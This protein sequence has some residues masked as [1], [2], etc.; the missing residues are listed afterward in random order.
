MP[1]G[2]GVQP[3][4]ANINNSLTG[5]AVQMR[6]IM[7]QA[8]NL[9]TQVNGTGQGLAYLE[10]A[11]FSSAAN[12]DNPGDQ[13][14]AAWALEVIAYFSTVAGVYFGTVQAGGSGGTGAVEFS[15]N[16]ALASLW[17]VQ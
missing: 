16:E 6:T 15:Y 7:Q 10:A 8:A 3:N 4:N 9:S 14:D 17:N 12:A 2:V 13:S 1:S 11:G 5:I